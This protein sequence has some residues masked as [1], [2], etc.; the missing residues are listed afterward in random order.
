MVI[1]IYAQNK[2]FTYKG[3][4]GSVDQLCWHKSNPDL[5]STASGDKTVKVW[6]VRHQKCS[7]T[8]LTKGIVNETIRMYAI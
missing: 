2:E 7:N 3:H 4:S 6:D 1:F 5:L 8:I